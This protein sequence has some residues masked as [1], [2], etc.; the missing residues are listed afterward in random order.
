[1]GLL[2]FA[3]MWAMKKFT[4]ESVSRTSVLVAVV[5]TTLLS[6]AVGFEHNSA[7]RIDQVVDKNTR[8]LLGNFSRVE[9]RIVDLN[10]Q[11][12]EKSA[13]LRELQKAR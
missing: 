7:A 11:V 9:R 5:A 4:P 12:T 2:A 8:E 13:Q 10:T 6:W 1:M 3:V